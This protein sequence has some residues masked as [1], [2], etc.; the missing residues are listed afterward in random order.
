[1]VHVYVICSYNATTWC[2]NIT[3]CVSFIE[4]VSKSPKG[5]ELVKRTDILRYDVKVIDY[6]LILVY[7]MVWNFASINFCVIFCTR[8][9]NFSKGANISKNKV[10]LKVILHKMTS[11]KRQPVLQKNSQ[12][13]YVE[14]ADNWELLLRRKNLIRTDSK[15]FQDQSYW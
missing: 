1:M 10:S 7:M 13:L 8:T 5:V 4:S 9:L 3:E 12:H 2:R 15:Y 11:E 14:Y 6:F